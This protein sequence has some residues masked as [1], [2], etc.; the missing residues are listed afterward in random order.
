MTIIIIIII[1]GCEKAFG[2]WIKYFAYEAQL[3]MA[4]LSTVLR[5]S[6]VGQERDTDEHTYF[7]VVC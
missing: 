3:G 5:H 4:A 7:V 2:K 6:F 1:M